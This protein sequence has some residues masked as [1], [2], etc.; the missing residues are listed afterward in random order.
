[1][2]PTSPPPSCDALPQLPDAVL[3]QVADHFRVLGEPT[4]LQILQWLVAQQ[5][6]LQARSNLVAAQA[7]RLTDSALL[8]QAVGAGWK[9][10]AS[11]ATL[12]GR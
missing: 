4:R 8:F 1:M 9:G 3:E 6:V 7:Q 5:Q 10:A 12:D 2:T 11:V